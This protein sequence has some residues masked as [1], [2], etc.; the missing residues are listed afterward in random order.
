MI[1]SLVISLVLL[2]AL[3]A[4]ALAQAHADTAMAYVGVREVGTNQGAEVEMFLAGVGLPVGNPWCAAFVTH[5]LNANSSLLEWPSIRSALASDFIT[6]QSH[7][8]SSVL[9]GLYEP[10]PGDLAIWLRGNTRFGHIGIV[11]SWTGTCGYV[12]EGNSR[13]IYHD[14][15]EGVWIKN[16]C[17]DPADYFR[18]VAFTTPIYRD[19]IALPQ[20]AQLFLS[21]R[22]TSPIYLD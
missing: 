4:D 22:L 21:R 8:A 19:F 9:M 6:R 16:R 5:C 13:N 11:L 3:S 14:G 20:P 18:I 17:I 12:I 10:Q 15:Q 7:K 1:R 2:H